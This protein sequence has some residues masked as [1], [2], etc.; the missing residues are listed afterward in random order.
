MCQTRPVFVRTPYISPYL[1]LSLSLSSV[2]STFKKSNLVL[3]YYLC[4]SRRDCAT[5]K[6]SPHDPKKESKSEA[7]VIFSFV[8][9][10]LICHSPAKIF[11][12]RRHLTFSKTPLVTYIYIYI[13]FI[14]EHKNLF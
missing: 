6:S 4:V 7:I 9:V 11:L 8:C 13:I 1:Y 14:R 12:K 3:N 2:C 5:T 10:R